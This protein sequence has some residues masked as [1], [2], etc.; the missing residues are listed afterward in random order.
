MITKTVTDCE[1][2]KDLA[3]N[4]LAKLK[5]EGPVF[6]IDDLGRFEDR[7]HK[8]AATRRAALAVLTKPFSE[9]QEMIENNRDF[10]VATA[11]ILTCTD[12]EL[13][14]ATHDLLENA[15]T[16]MVLLLACREDME[17]IIEE[18]EREEAQS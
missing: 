17:E 13:Y 7:L 14:Q 9:I 6:T 4:L 3:N 11:D 18:A 2:K 5:A 10:A 1:Q 12:P 8:N 15:R 16:R